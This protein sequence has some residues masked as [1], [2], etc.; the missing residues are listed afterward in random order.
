MRWYL[1]ALP[2]GEI[3]DVFAIDEKHAREMARFYLGTGKLPKGTLISVF[4]PS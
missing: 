4:V 2:A 1:V 3:F